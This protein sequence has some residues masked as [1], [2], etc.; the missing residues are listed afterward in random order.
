MCGSLYLYTHKLTPRKKCKCTP[1][2]DSHGPVLIGIIKHEWMVCQRYTG[3][4]PHI[5]YIIYNI[6]THTSP[7]GRNSKL[8]FYRQRREYEP[9]NE[10]YVRLWKI[11]RRDLDL[12]KAAIMFH[13]C[14]PPPV[15]GENRLW[16]YHPRGGVCYHIVSVVRYKVRIT[17]TGNIITVWTLRWTSNGDYVTPRSVMYY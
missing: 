2:D 7:Y 10:R 11:S 1:M 15:F 4:V 5:Y 9:N 13:V 8:I 14:A 12:P 17:L 3:Y 16:N 6:Y